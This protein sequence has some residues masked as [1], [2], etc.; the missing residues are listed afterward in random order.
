MKEIERISLVVPAYNEEKAIVLVIEEALPYVDEIVVVDDGSKD[1]TFAV[2]KD[3]IDKFKKKNSGYKT[4][5]LVRHEKNSGKVMALCSGVKNSSG[6]IVVFIDADFTYPAAAIPEMIKAI[7]NGADLV[8]GSRLK[9]NETSAKMH[10]LNKIG[11][12]VFSF[13]T[14]YISC[15]NV[16]DP[17]TGLRAFR[18]NTFEKLHVCAKSLEY[19]VKMSVRAAKLGYKIVEVPI[20]LRERIGKSKLNPFA[21]GLK[22]LFALM[23]IT[24]SETS[25][26]AKTIMLPSIIFVLMGLFFGFSSVIDYLIYGAPKHPYY[27]LLTVLG[28][29]LG[30]QLFSLGLIID[31]L[32]KKLVRIEECVKRAHVK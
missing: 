30:I 11:N 1:R 3:Y 31:N 26:L 4:I 18:K 22:M 28:S 25:I 6:D 10:L 20:V 12:N 32:T 14:S 24:Y 2:A 7:E 17:T 29:I 5:K 13:I 15:A 16:S 8:L 27:P 21:D 19:E 9:S 23:Q